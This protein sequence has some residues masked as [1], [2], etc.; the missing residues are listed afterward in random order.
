M[1][2]LVT[3]ATGRVGK[4]LVE[5]LVKQG[6]KVRALV[7]EGTV[8]N[9]QVEIFYGDVLNKESL[10]KAVEGVDVIYHL[11]AVVDYNAPKD[12][13]FNVNVIGARNLLEVTKIKKFI[14]LSSTAVMGKKLKEIPASEKTPCK[15]SNFYGETK[16]E[17]EKL[18][19]EAGGIILRSA[20][21]LGP[22]FME[23]YDYVLSHLEDGT[24][25]VPGDGKNFIQWVHID[26]VVQALLLAKENGKPGEVYIITGKEVKTLNDCLALLAKYLEVDPPKKHVSKFIATTMSSYK[27]VKSK[28]AGKKPI[29]LKE[30]IE[31]M[32]ANMSFDISKARSELGFEPKVD[33]E[34]VAKE[35][36]E[37]YKKTKQE[38]PVEV[39]NQQQEKV[40]PEQSEDK[41]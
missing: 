28:I 14:Y 40:S 6:E 30:F 39:L 24:M 12:I 27:S 25:Q 16:F 31:K 32:T 17:A 21:V 4:H 37:E 26:D 3:G 35:M 13:M 8:E 20:D 29:A 7:K 18:V 1:V 23:G 15:P 2:I 9:E 22:G 10:K 5:A 11:A 38:K 41:S 34:H 19:K 33:Y 36:V